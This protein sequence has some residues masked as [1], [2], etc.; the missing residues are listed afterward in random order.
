M[1]FN[2]VLNLQPV[3]FTAESKAVMASPLTKLIV[4]CGPTGAGKSALALWA[5]QQLNGIIINA[6]S[7]QI[8]H[9]MDIGTAKP[10]A[11][12]RALVEHRLFDIVPPNADFDA[13]AYAGMAGGVI[14]EATAR[15]KVPIVVGGTGFYIKA[16][17]YGLCDAPE[18]D[19]AVRKKYRDLLMVEGAP[20]LH[21]LLTQL[22]PV[23]AARLH[24]NDY[25][26]VMR[27]LEVLEATG[28]SLLSWQRRHGGFNE[29]RYDALQIGVKLE[30]VE[31]YA[32]I[33][34]RVEQMLARG[35]ES[36]VRGLLAKGFNAGLKSMSSI[37]YKQ[38]AAY[39]SGELDYAEM[40]RLIKRDT[41]HYAK[42]QLTWFSR[43][44]GVVWLAPG[45]RDAFIALATN[46]LLP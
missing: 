46:F 32:R 24:A 7:M 15:G 34:A 29:K 22:D 19:E 43:D 45:E 2:L 37:G 18:I 8:Y 23:M 33:D 35:L 11:D 17:L 13:A 21:E 6:D 12:E 16:L 5:A 44:P 41:R 39:I 9:G 20:F 10:D 42:R 4:I 36:E 3:D 25:V 26:R 31:L 1:I 28:E 27:A 14:A 30:R 38:M 40:A